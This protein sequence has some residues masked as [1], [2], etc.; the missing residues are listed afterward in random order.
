MNLKRIALLVTPPLVYVTLVALSI[1]LLDYYI[2]GFLV[3]YFVPPAGKESLIP[4]MTAFLRFKGFDGFTAVFVPVTLITATDA[5]TAFFVIWNF[6]L[7]LMIP[8]IGGVL[9]SVEIKARGIISKHNLAKKTYLGIFVF[10]FIP[11]QGTGSTTASVI[12]RL[13]GLEKVKL[14][15][16]IVIASL[17]SSLFMATVSNYIIGYR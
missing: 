8:K 17:L 6:D 12:G 9:K 3:A 16:T 1:E 13:L 11:F 15:T 5:I 4:L 14:F 10:V 2:V 7:I